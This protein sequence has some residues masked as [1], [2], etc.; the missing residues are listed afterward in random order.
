MHGHQ[1]MVT[2]AH[3]CATQAGEPEMHRKIYRTL[4]AP[5]HASM[6]A[7]GARNDASREDM[8][9]LENLL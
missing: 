3:R 2:N 4:C 1:C 9:Y 7:R 8:N 6:W 5:Q